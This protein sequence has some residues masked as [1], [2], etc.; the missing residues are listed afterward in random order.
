VSRIVAAFA[1]IYLFW[2]GTFLAI[3]YA[4]ADIPPLLTIG[5]RCL[6]GAL[7]LGAWA[8]WRRGLERPTGRQWLTAGVAGCFLFL[9]CHGLLA[10]AEQRVP[11]GQAALI[12]SA[13]PLWLVILSSIRE[14][15]L[16]PTVVLAGLGVGILGVSLLAD[17]AALQGGSLPDRLALIASG[18]SWA[19]GSV[20]SRDGARPASVAQSTAMQLAAGGV[21]VLGLSLASGE[22]AGWELDRVTPRA[23][24]SLGFLVIAG[25]ALGF[26]AYTWLLRVTT[27]AA[28]GTFAFVNP[29][30]ALA[31]AWAV[32]DE[33]LTLRTT[34]AAALVLGA[35]LMIWEATYA[36]HRARDIP[37]AAA[38][39]GLL[40]TS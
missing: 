29:V 25:T 20:I 6:A 15:R 26:A 36:S 27:A 8:L 13:E 5:V 9:G 11:S 10:W 12:L 21:V 18:L 19:I 1:A 7:L 28:V 4:V 17:G 22:L 32:G 14:R 33:T 2:G 31:L 34:I 35:V 23:A 37:E 39:R 30:V 16:P 24:F 38:D 40:H 3:R